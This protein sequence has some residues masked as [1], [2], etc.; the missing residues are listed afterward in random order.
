[1]GSEQGQLV[2]HFLLEYHGF[3]NVDCFLIGTNLCNNEAIVNRFWR[4]FRVCSIKDFK[5]FLYILLSR[6]R[7]WLFP[8]FVEGKRLFMGVKELGHK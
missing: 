5:V 8:F 3:R 4:I 7:H 6:F 2:G 1:M